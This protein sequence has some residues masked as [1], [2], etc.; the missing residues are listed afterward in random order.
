MTIDEHFEQ[1]GERLYEP[2]KRV[3]PPSD[4]AYTYDLFNLI[5]NEN[6]GDTGC[7]SCRRAVI[8]RVRGEYKR[9]KENNLRKS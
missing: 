5:T 6:R 9:W 8:N 1:N 2:D 3:W 7:G 4:L